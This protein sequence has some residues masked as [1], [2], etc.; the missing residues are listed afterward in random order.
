MAMAESV[1]DIA[2]DSRSA[3]SDL[4]NL[5]C[6]TVGG[7]ACIAI[8]TP[9]Y[10][11]T[12]ANGNA[13]DATAEAGSIANLR[14]RATTGPSIGEFVACFDTATWRLPPSVAAIR[15]ACCPRFSHMGS[16]VGLG[17]GWGFLSQEPEVVF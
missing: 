14:L 2:L 6:A 5:A 1:A 17:E 15:S 7:D 11:G 9:T 13:G 3:H 8:S 12:T 4:E 16:D 10:V